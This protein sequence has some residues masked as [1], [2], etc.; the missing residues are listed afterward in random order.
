MFVFELFWCR[1]CREIAGGCVEGAKTRERI[2]FGVRGSF[3]GYFLLAVSQ[4]GICALLFGDQEKEVLR[5]LQELFLCAEFVRDEE[6]MQEELTAIS[7]LLEEGKS[8]CSLPLD[9]RGTS[10]ER[11]VWKALLQ[12]PVG[13]RVSYSVL[14]Q[15]MGRADAVRA[16]ARAV[17]ANKVGFLIPC[18]RVVKKDGSLSGYR[19]GARRKELLQDRE[20]SFVDKQE[21]MKRGC[22]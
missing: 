3:L 7:L 2:V 22:R 10:F 8:N 19:W 12:L 4:K 18:H 11:D 1:V 21:E 16:V 14:A 15:R 5:E 6:K 17:A 9:V 20:R 13:E